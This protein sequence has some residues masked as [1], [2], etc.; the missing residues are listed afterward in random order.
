MDCPRCRQLLTAKTIEQIELPTCESCSGMFLESGALDRIAEPHAGDLEFSTLDAET[1][2][3]EDNYGTTD[4]PRCS[5]QPMKKVEFNI[6]TGII[7]DYCEGCRGFWLDGKELDRINDEVRALNESSS[8]PVAP[9]ML[10]FAN[11]I[12][13]LPR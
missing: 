13:S 12:W 6:Y 3:H 4:C 5:G 10:W 2:S 1:F 9:A 8:E 11:F 7:L